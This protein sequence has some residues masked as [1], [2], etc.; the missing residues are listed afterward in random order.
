MTRK[1]AHRRFRSDVKFGSQQGASTD[2]SVNIQRENDMH[3]AIMTK[4]NSEEK[5]MTS[6]IR[7]I[8]LPSR[9]ARG[10]AHARKYA[11]DFGAKSSQWTDRQTHTRTKTDVNFRPKF[12]PRKAQRLN[13]PQSQRF[14]RKKKKKRNR[15]DATASFY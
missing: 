13:T 11:F 14:V 4:Q 1:N 5:N 7:E 15:G 10:N 6:D 9:R 2:I 12:P 8:S 3:V